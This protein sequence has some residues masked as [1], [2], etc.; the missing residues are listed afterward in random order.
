M[1]CR[2]RYLLTACMLYTSASYANSSTEY[3]PSDCYQEDYCYCQDAP[4]FLCRPSTLSLGPEVYYVQ[5]SRK[6]GTKQHG[7]PM[8]VRLTYDYIKRYCFYVGGQAFYGT[9]TLDGHTGLGSKIRSRLTDYQIEGS[10]GYT[11]QMR[12][13]PYFALTPYLGY[14]YF[15]EITKFSPPSPLTLK[16]TI[17]YDYVAFGFLSS[18]YITPYFSAGLNVRM[19]S[20]WEA[21]CKISD[22]PDFENFQQHVGDRIQYRIELP[23]TYTGR[24]IGNCDWLQIS[25]VPFYEQRLYGERENFPFDFLKTK[26]NIYGANLQFIFRF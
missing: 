3:T 12:C 23:L 26:L 18:I 5:R 24:T 9:G 25:L 8:G 11:F 21:R 13:C 20:P 14:G 4:P 15:R 17:Q 1:I 2:L 22:D 16:Y 6:G 10:L 7:T 19:R